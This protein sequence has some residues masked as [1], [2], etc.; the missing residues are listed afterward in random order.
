M[1]H[2]HSGHLPSGGRALTISAWLT[3]LYFVV[4]LGIGIWTGSIAVIS[5]AF[6]T[7][8]AVGGVLVAI[9]AARIARRPADS[10]RSFGWHRAEIVGA[11]INGAFLLAMALIVIGMAA[12][13]LSSPID[14]PTGPMLWA[15]AGGLV[16]EV[17]SLGLLWK[18]GRRDL[19]TRGAVWHIVQTFVGSLL[20]IVTALVIQFT[21]FLLIDPL[22]GMAFGFVL[23]WAS[24]GILKESIHMLMEG[25]P[26]DVDLNDV[27]AAIGGLEG[28]ADVHHVH[29]WTLTSGKDV[30]SGHVLM[31]S[32][33]DAAAVLPAAHALLKEKFGFF[34]VTLQ[35]EDRCLD[36]AGAEDIDI[37]R[38]H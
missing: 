26:E 32:G 18:E 21:G 30:F 15:A 20:I 34:L 17:I 13:R 23:V 8:S 19:N 37:T 1:D 4:E 27:I 12:M 10:D 24:W 28:V 2:G 31:S 5:D 9:V 22:L 25:T 6:H 29:A 36:E 11:A 14:L 38:T 3:G 16:T 33:A 35:V 7:F